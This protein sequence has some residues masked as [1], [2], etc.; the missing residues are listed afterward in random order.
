MEVPKKFVAEPFSYHQELELEIDSLTNMALGVARYGDDDWVIFVPHCLPGERVKAR[1]FRNEKNCSHAD[2][3][4]VIRESPDRVE[5]K[6]KL[7]GQCGGCQYQNLRYDKQLEVKTAQVAELLEHMADLTLEVNPAIAS[8]KEWGYRSKITPHFDR[9]RDG[10]IGPI[11]F[12]KNGRGRQ[13]IDVYH[14]PIAMDEINEALPKVRENIHATARYAK[15]GVTLLLRVSEGKVITDN[16]MIATE[17]VGGQKFDFLAGEFFQNNPFILPQFTGYVRDQASAGNCNYLVDAYCGSGLFAVALAPSFQ[18]VAG[19]EVNEACAD[20]ARRN[21]EK[22]GLT[23]TVFLGASAEAIF[24]KIT[25]PAAEST[26]II[27]PPRKGSS[28]EFLEQLI[29]FGPQRIVYVSCN[30]ATQARDLKPLTAANY[31][32]K[33]VQPF[34]LFPHTKH[35]ECVVVLEKE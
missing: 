14:C 18:Q 21:A 7:F 16:R 28:P 1:I 20:W 15:K 35:L 8:P 9:P 12:Q 6:C 31:T 25:F 10:K 24:E 19:V 13:L 11:G 27:D 4:E 23:N 29:I 33:E 22:N 17:H 5:P 32:V 26:V 30:P 2:L 3:L 34:D